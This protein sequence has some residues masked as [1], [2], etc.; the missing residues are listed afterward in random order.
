[1]KI[2]SIGIAFIACGVLAG[3]F[4]AHAESDPENIIKFRQSVMKANGAHMSAAGAI[5][6]GKVEYKDRL[7]DHAKALEMFTKNIPALFPKGSD[8]GADSKALDSVWAKPAEFE[9][10]SKDTQTKAAA[11][12]KAVAA[13][14]AQLAPKFKEL[15]DSCKAC[16]KDFRKEEKE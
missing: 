6:Q 14:D 2:K 5:V 9:K 16:H 13:K 1:M 4:A 10:L 3:S 15:A 12:A 7:A 11:F 8:F